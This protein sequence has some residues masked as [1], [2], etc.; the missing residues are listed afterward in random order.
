MER[1]SATVVLKRGREKPV[2]NRH[3]WIFSGALQHIEGEVRDGDLVRVVDSQG[4]YLATGYLNR[5][6]Q[7]VVR[8][9][10][11]DDQE[12]LDLGF[13]RARLHR[14]IAGRGLLAADPATNAYRLV[15]AE[16]D[17]LPGLVVD[18]YGDWLVVQCLTL[19]MA[20]RR[21]KIVGLLVDLQRPGGVYARDDAEV[22][23]K[24]GLPLERRV[25]AGTDPP[26]RILVVEQGHRFLVDIGEGHKTG[27]YL[28]QRE[29][30]WSVAEYCAGKEILNAFAYTG[31]FGVYAGRAGARHV[32]NIDTSES[33]LALAGENLALNGCPPQEMVVADVFQVLRQYRDQG[34]RFDLVV[35]DPPKF[36]TS[37][38]SVRSATRGYK[39]VNL[40]A[41]QLLPPG[42]LLVSFSCSGLVS[43]DLFQKVLFGASVDAEREVQI[44]E[45]LAQGSDHPVLLTFPESAYLKGFICR[46]W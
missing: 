24:E 10:T 42:G 39:D 38:A 40:L 4:S 18:R 19:G 22:R 13:W 8:L 36:A 12:A 1:P 28:D 9:L 17:G 6:S 32:V 14:A 2:R 26:D 16:A 43:T 27:F 45:R 11:W 21:E 5:R 15:H 29:N 41:M 34:R 46:V 31:G 23:Q 30:R 44:L 3:P 20:R 35:L 37:R 33:A 25:L 7:I